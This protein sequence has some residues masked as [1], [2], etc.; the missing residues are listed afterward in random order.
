MRSWSMEGAPP[1]LF[2][3]IFLAMRCLSRTINS[4]RVLQL[5]QKIE[6]AFPRNKSAQTQGKHT[7]SNS[8]IK[9]ISKSR[10]QDET[11]NRVQ[12]PIIPITF[13]L[14]LLS[15]KWHWNKLELFVEKLFPRFINPRHESHLVSQYAKILPHCFFSPPSSWSLKVTPPY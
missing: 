15:D 14:Y 9:I 7:C 5:C 3:Y 6:S 8:K 1:N 13:L 4:K 12:P 11:T 10:Q 2:W